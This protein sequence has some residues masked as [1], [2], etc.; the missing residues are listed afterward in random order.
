MKKSVLWLSALLLWTSLLIASPLSTEA[1]QEH[2]S[3]PLSVLKLKPDPVDRT[4]TMNT[5]TFA[6]A[7]NQWIKSIAKEKGYEA[8]GSATWTSAP[9]GPGTHGW[10]VLLQSGGREVGYLVIHAADPNLPNAYQLSEYG[11]GSSPLFSLNTLYRS[12]VQLELIDSSYEA[13]RWYADPLHAVWIVTAGEHTHF[14]DAWTG[15][16][17]PLTS[18]DQLPEASQPGGAEFINS[19]FASP[20]HTITANRQLDGFDPYDDM[21]WLQKTPLTPTAFTGLQA[22][23]DAASPAKLTFIAE[24]YEGQVNLPFAVT[25]YQQW[26][27]DEVYMQLERD[28]RRAIPARYAAAAGR[29]FP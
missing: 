8:W 26:S 4:K 29:L 28:G 21:S 22:L 1:V 9:L 5:P 13:E 20:E 11:S 24:L 3:E 2:P 16:V 19:A 25:G 7:V 27:N 17:L 14:L 10:I 15:E 12:L 18:R 6:D 23:L